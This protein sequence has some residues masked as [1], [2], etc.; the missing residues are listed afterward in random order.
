MIT[1]IVSDS[2]TVLI[3][4]GCILQQKDGKLLDGVPNSVTQLASKVS[5]SKIKQ[6]EGQ[7][8]KKRVCVWETG[9]GYEKVGE[10]NIKV[11]GRG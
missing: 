4:C 3:I 9:E 8:I 5:T 6:S 1:S 7:I 2:T 11:R 10:W